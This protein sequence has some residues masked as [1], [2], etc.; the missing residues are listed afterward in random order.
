VC[1]IPHGKATIVIARGNPKK[2]RSSLVFCH[3]TGPSVV[4]SF[5]KFL[6]QLHGKFVFPI[7]FRGDRLRNLPSYSRTQRKCKPKFNTWNLL[8]NSW[9]LSRSSA[10]SS[11]LGDINPFGCF[12]DAARD[13]VKDTGHSRGP[14]TN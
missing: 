3:Y 5:T 9:T 12:V 6:P 4:P 8:V 11:A 1:L 7:C 14:P 13:R 10:S 2:P